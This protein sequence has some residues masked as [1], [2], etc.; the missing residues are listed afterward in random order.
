MID[1]KIE[2]GQITIRNISGSLLRTTTDI[3]VLIR[4][5]YDLISKDNKE[6]AEEYKRIIQSF[7]ANKAWT[8]QEEINRVV[9]EKMKEIL[10][11]IKE[12]WDK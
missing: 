5:I 9:G 11:K 10:D 12:G 7:I 6:A 4:C 3:V 1:V 2:N 8:P